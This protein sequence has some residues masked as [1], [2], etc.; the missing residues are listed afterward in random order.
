MSFR[1]LLI[2]AVLLAGLGQTQDLRL[3][4]SL[5]QQGRLAEVR[6]S[7]PEL[8]KQYPNHPAIKYLHALTVTDGDSSVALFRDL[9]ENHGGSEYAGAAAMKIGEYLYARG[10]YSQA[11]VQLRQIPLYY[12]SSP[13]IQRA[14]DLMVN[15]YK[16]TGEIDS[17]AYYLAR[18]KRRYPDLNYDYGIGGLDEIEV[19][20]GEV[21]L[22]KLD[23]A[24]VQQKLQEAEPPARPQPKAAVPRPWIVQVGAFGNYANALSLKTSLEEN[25]YT[26]E[27][28]EV[29]SANRRLHAVRVVR[30][31]SRD[32]AGTIG[33][34]LKRNYGLNYLVMN[35]PE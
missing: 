9:I 23:K 5:V 12:S 34:E 24:Q 1:G 21:E 13:H 33:D 6:Q 18:F 17:A 14:M 29:A 30:F 31:A 4:F 7:V 25:G 26:V 10:L 20:P 28:H 3:Y 32:Q 15:S 11:G 27:I 19:P 16:A 2:G 8:L 35:R 22:V